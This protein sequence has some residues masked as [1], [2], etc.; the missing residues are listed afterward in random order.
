MAKTIDEVRTALWVALELVHSKLHAG[1]NGNNYTPKQQVLIAGLVEAVEE[2]Q[3]DL[4]RAQ[5]YNDGEDTTPVQAGFKSA[6]STESKPNEPD[7]KLT[8]ALSVAVK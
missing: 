6:L 8:G 5:P 7:V 3:A 4:D 1:V 2:L